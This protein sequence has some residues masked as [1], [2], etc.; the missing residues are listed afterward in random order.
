MAF[1]GAQSN[2]ADEALT[3]DPKHGEEGERRL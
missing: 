2:M 3:C 1:A